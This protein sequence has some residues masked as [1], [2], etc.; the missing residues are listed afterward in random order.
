MYQKKLLQEIDKNT[1]SSVEE[2]QSDETGRV[3]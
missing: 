2:Q 3:M 1:F